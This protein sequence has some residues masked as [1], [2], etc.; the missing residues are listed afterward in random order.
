MLSECVEVEI[1][2]FLERE[3]R[4]KHLE[5]LKR[6]GRGIIRDDVAVTV[7]VGR[8]QNCHFYGL[9]TSVNSC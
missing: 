5:M 2:K 9:L 4:W 7:Q 8:A 3:G 1:R 6:E